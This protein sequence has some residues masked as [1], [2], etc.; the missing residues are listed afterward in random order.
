MFLAPGQNQCDNR[1][2]SV[3]RKGTVMRDCRIEQNLYILTEDLT[4]HST[5]YR[6]FLTKLL[7]NNWSALLTS[8]P[9]YYTCSVTKFCDTIVT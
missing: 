2:F 7:T 5:Q 6:N 8:P 4:K 1:D 3:F 9:L